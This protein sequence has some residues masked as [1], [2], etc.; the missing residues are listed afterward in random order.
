MSDN[1][2]GYIHAIH[3][4]GHFANALIKH[5]GGRGIETYPIYRSKSPKKAAKGPWSEQVD[6]DRAKYHAQKTITTTKGPCVIF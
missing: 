1:R 3:A 4:A 5:G 6:W 2:H